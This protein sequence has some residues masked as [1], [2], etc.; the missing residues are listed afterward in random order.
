[1]PGPMGT[2]GFVTPEA[3]M[4]V[5]VIAKN[6]R[7][8]VEEMFS[9]A[10]QSNSNFDQHLGEVEQRL[11]LK[12]I[13]DLAA[14]L[15]SEATFAIDGALIPVPSWKLAVEVYSPQRL[16]HSLEQLV[17]AFNR[18]AETNAVKLTLTTEDANGR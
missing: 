5:S 14:P 9:L 12:L 7:S 15:G 13:D 4:A 6:P 2:L 17:Q 11:G 16:Q 10:R 8:I 3:G 1:S 18:N